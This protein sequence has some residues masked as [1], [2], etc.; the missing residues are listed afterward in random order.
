MNRIAVCLF[1]ILTALS[2]THASGADYP[3]KS[4]RLIVPFAAGGGTDL[5]ARLIAKNNPSKLTYGSAG[6]NSSGHLTG[7]MFK[8]AMEKL[9][10]MPD[11]ATRMAEFGYD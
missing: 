1:G 6:P 7:E 3:T 10:Q 5:L 9:A 2:A 8:A 4:I 11:L